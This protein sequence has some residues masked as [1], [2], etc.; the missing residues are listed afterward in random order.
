M[1]T[2]DSFLPGYRPCVGIMLLNRQGLVWVGRRADAPTEAEGPGTWWQMPQ[3]GID[4][5][6]APRSAVVR[7]LFE[8][9]GIGAASVSIITEMPGWQ[10]Y[11]LPPSLQGKAW[12]GRYK[13]QRQKWFAARFL[14]GDD[15]VSITPE[16]PHQIEFDAWRWAPIGEVEGLIVP[17][18]RPV[19]TE[20]VRAFAPL[21]VPG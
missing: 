11:D 3:G 15:E 9:T 6:E 2:S 14:G 20:V 12:G 21:A 8:E 10:Y 1:T 4:E 18:K 17:F 16:P 19:Y 7:E 13:G 5:N